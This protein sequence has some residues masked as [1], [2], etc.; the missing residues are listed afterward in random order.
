MTVKDI[1]LQEYRNVITDLEN[2]LDKNGGQYG[3]TDSYGFRCQKEV[4]EKVLDR[5]HEEATE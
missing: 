1:I 5:I 2:S 4:L 3:R